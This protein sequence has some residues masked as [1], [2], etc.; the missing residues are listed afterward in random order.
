[1]FDAPYKFRYISSSSKGNDH[2]ES[3][4]H[5]FTFYGKKNL[6]YI[7]EAEEFHYDFFILG[8]YLERDENKGTNEKYGLRSYLY[9]TSRV[10]ATCVQIMKQLYQKNSKSSFGFIGTPSVD[11]QKDLDLANTKRYRV[12]SQLMANV[13]SPDSFQHY[14][15]KERSMYLL[16]NRSQSKELLREMTEFLLSRWNSLDD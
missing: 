5:R 16:I 6:C 11:D 4:V 8:F 15:D 7:V 2:S 13:V 1:M 9:D 14:A 12:Y 3:E 10:L